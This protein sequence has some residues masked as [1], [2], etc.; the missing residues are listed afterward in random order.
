MG[1]LLKRDVLQMTNVGMTYREA[2]N[3]IGVSANRAQQLAGRGARK[4]RDMLRNE[5]IIFT[6]G[7]ILVSLIVGMP[8]GY[9]FFWYGRDHGFFG[10]DVY[11]IPFKEI[12]AM[13][14]IL[15][16]LQISLSYILS[17]N[18]KRESIVERIRYQE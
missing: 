14:I 8:A 3:S 12:I 11:H 15:S 18:V 9:G 16:V 6:L 5:G 2:G 7:S 1:L 10:L 17:R 4:V 13:I